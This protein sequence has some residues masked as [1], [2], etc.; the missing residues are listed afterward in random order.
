MFSLSIS[1]KAVTKM[2]LLY[3][4]SWEFLKRILRICENLECSLENEIIG[5]SLLRTL[6]T[7]HHSQL[8]HNWAIYQQHRFITIGIILLQRVFSKDCRK[9]SILPKIS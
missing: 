6:E 2:I 3:K 1:S 5:S 7:L 9:L 8:N 4:R